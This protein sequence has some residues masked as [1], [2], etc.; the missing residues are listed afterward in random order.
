MWFWGFFVI[1]IVSSLPQHSL[2]L[3]VQTRWNSPYLMIERFP[4]QYPAI[5]AGLDPQLQKGLTKDNQDRLKDEDFH[6]AEEIVQLI[7]IN[8]TSTLCVSSEKNAT[9]GQILPI[10]QILEEKWKRI[11]CLWQ[12]SK[13]RCGRS[14]PSDIKRR[15]SSLPVWSHSNRPQILREVNQWCK[16]GQ[17]EEESCWQHDR[18]WRQ[19]R[20]AP[21]IGGG[22][23]R[24]PWGNWGRQFLYC[25]KQGVPWRNCSQSRTGNW[26]WRSK[27]IP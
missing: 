22:V 3:D 14:S 24:R 8:Y 7:R 25:T 26:G 21:A 20:R 9:C 15:N 2:I 12:L 10:L 27:R 23:W 6:K 5:Q 18:T 11:Q 19:D 4:E 1:V 16:L 13:R 17:T